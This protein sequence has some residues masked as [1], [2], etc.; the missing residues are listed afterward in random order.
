[1]SQYYLV[2][3]GNQKSKKKIDKVEKIEV[4]RWNDS[5]SDETQTE[6]TATVQNEHVDFYKIFNPRLE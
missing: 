6:R 4:G 1:M 3:R 5:E 2:N